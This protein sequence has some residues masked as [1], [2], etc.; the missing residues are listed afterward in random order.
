MAV[1]A[2][3]TPRMSLD[4]GTWRYYHVVQYERSRV[5][6]GAALADTDM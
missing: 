1:R 6:V 5:E 4:T 3:I 2:R